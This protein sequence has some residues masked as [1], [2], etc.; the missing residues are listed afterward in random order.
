MEEISSFRIVFGNAPIVKV[1]DFFLDNQEFDYSLTDIAK[2]SDIGW[3]TLHL[4]WDKLTSLGI[5]KKTRRIGRAELYILNT[6]NPIVKQLIELD[7][8]VS[9]KLMRKKQR[10]IA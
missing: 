10:V 6:T 3:S 5:V 7:K 1:I 9:L 4:F 2:N 8:I